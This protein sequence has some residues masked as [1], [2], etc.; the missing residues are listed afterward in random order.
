MAVARRVY[1]RLAKRNERAKTPRVVDRRSGKKSEEFLG[2]GLCRYDF[3][4]SQSENCALSMRV[5]S[6][7]KG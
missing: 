4:N 1:D 6:V 5:D 2:K 3:R 7:E